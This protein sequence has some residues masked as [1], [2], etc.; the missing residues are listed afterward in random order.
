MM[1]IISCAH[2][3]SLSSVKCI[4][5]LLS[6]FQLDFFLFVLL[7]S[8][9]CSLYILNTSPLLD[10]WFTSVLSQSVAWFFILFIGS[11]KEQKSLI[12]MRPSLSTFPFIDCAF[13]VKESYVPLLFNL[14][15]AVL[16]KSSTS[17]SSVNIFFLSPVLEFKCILW[18]S[19]LD[20]FEC[21]YIPI[22]AFSILKWL[23]SFCTLNI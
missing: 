14:F 2:L 4:M 3:P 23:L 17:V 8:S 12:L 7:L 15:L 20:G 1:L 21:E 5:C 22:R 16:Y 13:G 19:A 6:I 9:E 10:T 11:F 18:T